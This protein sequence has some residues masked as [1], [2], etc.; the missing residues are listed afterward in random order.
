MYCG[1]IILKIGNVWGK[2]K[3]ME[4]KRLIISKLT[5]IDTC[6]MGISIS[7]EKREFPT[8]LGD[9][10]HNRTVLGVPSGWCAGGQ[11]LGP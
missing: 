3:G 1:R 8:R 10:Q 9:R 4:E 7:Y 2:E 6:V 11:R 5:S